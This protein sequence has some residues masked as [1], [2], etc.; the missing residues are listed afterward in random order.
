[1][2]GYF[3]FMDRDITQK[4]SFGTTL[5]RD[6]PSEWWTMYKKNRG[7][8]ENWEVFS[9]ALLDRFGSSIRAKRAHAKVLQL[10]QN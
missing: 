2:E 8:P 7:Y 5:L 10:Q 4:L 1:M 6:A 9:Q 3:Q